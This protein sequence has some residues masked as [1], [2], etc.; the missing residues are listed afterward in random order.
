MNIVVVAG[1]KQT[2]FKN[3]SVFPKVL[4]PT[5]SSC[6]ILKEMVDKTKPIDM[7]LKRWIVINEQQAPMLKTYIQV[8]NLE[9]D[10]LVIESKN[11][12]GSFNTL[13]EVK[14]QLPQDNVLFI[15]SDLAVSDFS[16][17]LK[18]CESCK[19]DED[20]VLFTNAGHYRYGAS[21]YTLDDPRTRLVDT[22]YYS[23]SY[24]GNIP[25]LYFLKNLSIFDIVDFQSNETKDLVDA[26]ALRDLCMRLCDLKD[27]GVELFEYRDLGVYKQHIKSDF[28]EDRCQTRFFNSLTISDDEK[29]LT[30]KA[31]DKNYVH[32]IEKEI[33]WYSRY[34]LFT[35][36]KNTA[37]AVPNIHSSGVDY[38]VMDYLKDY[39]PLHEVLDHLE[40]CSDLLSIKN[41]YKNIF[42]TVED[43]T[44]ASSIVVPFDDFKRDLK[45]EVVDK[46]ISRCE[47]IKG[48]LLNYKRDYLES[49]L[50]N[51]YESLLEF[52]KS[53]QDFSADPD[54]MKYWFCHGDL[55][56]SN[57]MV[58]E[59][60]LEVK[61]IDPRGYFGDTKMYGWKPYEIAKLLYCLYGYDDFNTKPQIYF[62]DWPKTRMSLEFSGFKDSRFA[63]GSNYKYYQMLVGVIYVAL[64]GYISQ[65]IMKANIAYDYGMRLLA[66]T[67]GRC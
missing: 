66:W 29:T 42:S 57:I 38:F 27:I 16:A 51:V 20:G 65:D 32:L 54:S 45:K 36:G 30:K 31:I 41:L 63:S 12:N 39:K 58:D 13:K 59:K 4:L 25:G 44:S 21:G 60:S 28:K 53:E 46:V 34:R 67:S 48:F 14:D 37:D 47:K 33:E 35:S 5:A 64:A 56:G 6:S 43:V 15:W 11:T 10:I 62:E 22:I 40:T 55:N 18:Q 7:P 49:V 3:L 8:N 26:L 2:R 1:G 24:E 61:F 9:D 17:I 50:R 52:A 23:S 19:D